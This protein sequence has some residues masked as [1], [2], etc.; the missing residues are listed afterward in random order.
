MSRTTLLLS[1]PHAG[2]DNSAPHG[3]TCPFA[4]NCSCVFAR[5]AAAERNAVITRVAQN[6]TNQPGAIDRGAAGVQTGATF[7]PNTATQTDT[8]FQPNTATQTDTTTETETDTTT[9][10]QTDTATQA[11][12]TEQ[13]DAAHV[14][15]TGFSDEVQESVTFWTDRGWN[16]VTASSSEVLFERRAALPFCFNVLLCLVSAFLWLAYWIPSARRPKIKTKI[17]TISADGS[18]EVTPGASRRE[19]ALAP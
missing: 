4:S 19:R 6:A 17:M 10:T 2:V 8:A 1:P 9:E 18:T 13:T 3:L 16:V 12:T 14:A 11:N 15:L 7:Q 5:R